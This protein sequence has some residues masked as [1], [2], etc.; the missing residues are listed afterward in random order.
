MCYA[1][2]RKTDK[3]G[4]YRA[5]SQGTLSSVHAQQHWIGL[6]HLCAKPTQRWG[7]N[8]TSAA[9]AE[10]L[11]PLCRVIAPSR[12]TTAATGQQQTL[13]TSSKIGRKPKYKH[14]S[15]RMID[16]NVIVNGQ[17]P[18]DWIQDRDGCGFSDFDTQ[19]FLL[20]HFNVGDQP[21]DEYGRT[22][23]DAPAVTRLGTHLLAYRAHVEAWP[24][25]L[26]ITERSSRG[27]VHYV[28]EREAVLATIDKTL[29]MAESALSRG[30]ELVFFGD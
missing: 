26:S 4:Y 19:N 16:W 11:I 18:S 12:T 21:I 15:Y 2:N 23:F 13:V 25:T 20:P 28:I 17:L 5:R 27:E 9:S 7:R 14:T 22:V 24:A 29:S 10:A 8:H 30:G 3:L 6:R 1:L